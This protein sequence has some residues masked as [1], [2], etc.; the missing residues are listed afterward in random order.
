MGVTHPSTSGASQLGG[1]GVAY[2]LG[3]PGNGGSGTSGGTESSA[4]CG[5]GGG[6][7]GS[8]GGGGSTTASD[9]GGNGG[10]NGGDGHASLGGQPGTG[11][12]HPSWSSSN[13]LPAAAGAAG[14]NFSGGNAGFVILTYVDPTGQCLL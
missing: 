4:P 12:N 5:G 6:G 9:V 8:G 13:T 1:N 11:A 2:G 14:G 3:S 10:D 7:L